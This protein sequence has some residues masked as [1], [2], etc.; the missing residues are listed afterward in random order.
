M[1][2]LWHCI[3]RRMM[4]NQSRRHVVVSIGLL[5]TLVSKFT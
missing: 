3:H 2:A 4:E 1:H 5:L